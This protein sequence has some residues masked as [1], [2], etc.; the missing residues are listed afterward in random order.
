MV[1]VKNYATLLDSLSCTIILLRL[2]LFNLLW[3][4]SCRYLAYPQN[5]YLSGFQ[6]IRSPSLGILRRATKS[7]R[8]RD[9][10]GAASK[11]VIQSH[12][13]HLWSWHY[14][15]ILGF[16]CAHCHPSMLSPL[17]LYPSRH[18]P[19]GSPNARSTAGA[20]AM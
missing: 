11:P 2:I 5:T 7:S 4:Y 18:M 17:N 15:Q 6:N 13:Y 19:V 12:R 20:S 9:R 8:S 14:V 3:V 16:A 1:V 10:I